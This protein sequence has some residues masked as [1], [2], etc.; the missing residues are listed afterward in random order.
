MNNFFVKIYD[1][2]LFS[3]TENVYFCCLICRA[4]RLP[5]ECFHGCMYT[6]RVEV[7]R[8]EWGDIEGLHLQL[9]VD[10]E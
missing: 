3:K 2:V 7:E 4:P 10:S 8:G 6:E 5:L 1:L 9:L